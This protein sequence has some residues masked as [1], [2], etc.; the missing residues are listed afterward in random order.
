MEDAGFIIGS[1]V[2]TF[3]VVA[4]YAWW[5]VRRGRKVAEKVP[6]EEKYWA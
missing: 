6:D 3:G 1:Y 4:A 5:V 2:L